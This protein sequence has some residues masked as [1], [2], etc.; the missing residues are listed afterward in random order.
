VKQ[1]L[2]MPP[3]KKGKP[4]ERAVDSAVTVGVV[5][6]KSGKTVS[7]VLPMAGEE[8]A[9]VVTPQ[10]AA[11]PAE[12][13]DEEEVSTMTSYVINKSTGFVKKFESRALALDFSESIR[14]VAP[15]HKNFVIR[16]FKTNEEML[17]FLVPDGN[18]VAASS[19]PAKKAKLA[20]GFQTEQS[21]VPSDA[22]MTKYETGLKN[23]INQI[24]VFHIVLEGAEH[25]V[26]GF[27]L[28]DK[29]TD[30]WTWKPAVV[31]KAILAEKRFPLFS[32]DKTTL[33]DMLGCVRCS[34]VRDVPN[35]PNVPGLI[36]FGGGKR[37][38]EKTIL[39]GFMDSP[40]FDK[41]VVSNVFD[42]TRKFEDTRVQSAYHIAMQ[43]TMKSS[44]LIQET[45]P[46]GLLWKKLA[47]GACNIEYHKFDNLAQ[48][49]L[50]K[51]IQEIIGLA[52][53]CTG[54]SAHLWEE[55]VWKMAYGNTKPTNPGN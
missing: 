22:E 16:E 48:V 17:E 26:W 30:Y 24:N 51:T 20:P 52:Y 14:P 54:V 1:S 21:S 15:D 29:G 6:E 9:S 53:D 37:T 10:K 27:T 31:E 36:T 41:A 34:F 47:A 39:W 40:T 44:V 13:E 45:I 55:N 35:G 28:K 19:K 11:K 42:L 43:N 2:E 4:I 8:P 7:D 5:S 38:M 49:F 32:A 18:A 23:A 46:G 25:D 50:D 3:A 12:N 33:D